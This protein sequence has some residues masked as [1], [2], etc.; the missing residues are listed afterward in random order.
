MIDETQFAPGVRV[1]VIDDLCSFCSADIGREGML[2][3]ISQTS[4]DYTIVDDHGCRIGR[5]I[6]PY[7][8]NCRNAL[9][10]I[11]E[12]SVPE[13]EQPNYNKLLG[14]LIPYYGCDL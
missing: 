12:P 9:E 1:R 4:S 5:I 7:C 6:G 13:S 11:E 3:K 10:V 8:V 2:H 14:K